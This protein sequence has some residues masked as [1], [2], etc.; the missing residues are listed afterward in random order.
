MDA[1]LRKQWPMVEQDQ[2]ISDAVVREQSRLRNFIRRRVADPGDAEDILQEVFYEFVETYRMMKPVEHVTGWF[3]QVARNRITDL[4]RK[5]SREGA[6]NE[7]IRGGENQ[8]ERG[9]GEPSEELLLEELLPSPD[10]GPDAAYARSVLLE[11]IDE[12]LDE[13]PAE[14]REVFIAHELMGYSFKEISAQT[15]VS[16]NT[17]LSRKHYAVLHLRERLQSVYDEFT[18]P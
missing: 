17:L 6:R 4:F 9:R 5:K 12:A 16:V 7:P 2:R 13:L 10:A 3:Y 11:E 18:K 15:G 14:Q 1:A 8:G